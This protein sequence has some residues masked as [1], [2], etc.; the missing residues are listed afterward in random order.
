LEITD[1]NRKKTVNIIA[2][3]PL[4]VTYTCTSGHLEPFAL[5][6]TKILKNPFKYKSYPQT[7]PIN[8]SHSYIEDN[9]KYLYI[10]FNEILT[11]LCRRCK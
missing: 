6:K 10:T 11:N 9:G 5:A 7:P 4:G 2:N 3:S 8:P 1:D